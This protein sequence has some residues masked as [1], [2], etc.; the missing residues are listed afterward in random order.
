M[1]NYTALFALIT[2]TF[3]ASIRSKLNGILLLFSLGLLASMS[4]LSASS[5]NEDERIIKDLGL[6]V[7]S[8]LS[9]GG[10]LFL[11]AQNLHRELER[12]S[13]FCLISKPISRSTF[14]WG[15]YIGLVCT[16][17][18]FLLLMTCAWCILAWSSQ[19]AIE[20]VMFKAIWLIWVEVAVIG[21]IAH[22]IGSFS[23]PLVTAGLSFGVFLVG[24]FT[25]DIQH[26]AA[27]AIRLNSDSP[28]LEFSESI[29]WVIPDLSLYNLSEAVLYQ[30][31]IPLDY[32]LKLTLSGCAYGI[33]CLS[34]ACW[35]FSKRDLV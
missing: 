8:T 19:V 32:V 14:L 27:R 30:G 5:L 23:T 10:M 24:R 18:F 22:L 13:L 35:I 2:T 6:F 28:L 20:G 26:L 9:I 3:K 29:L 17:G 33:I 25:P 16:S 1:I 7:L 4:I 21:A 34:G 12:K 15:K 31:H 11:S